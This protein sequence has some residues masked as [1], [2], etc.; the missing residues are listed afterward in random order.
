MATCVLWCGQ[1]G[2]MNGWDGA[3]CI[4]PFVI[5][6][7]DIPNGG[8]TGGILPLGNAGNGGPTGVQE[9]LAPSGHNS[10]YRM[11][12]TVGIIGAAGAKEFLN[13]YPLPCDLRNFGLVYG[14][15]IDWRIQ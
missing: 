15:L 13:I 3:T 2:T 7:L 6:G 11:S 4:D 9:T 5:A 1:P 10:G 8:P 14:L 12:S